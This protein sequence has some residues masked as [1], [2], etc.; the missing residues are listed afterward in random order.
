MLSNRWL[1]SLLQIAVLLISQVGLAGGG[2]PQLLPF[3]GRITDTGGNPINY[4]VTIKF[5]IYPPA[6]SCYIYEETQAVTPTS[7][8][9]ISVMLGAAANST[10]PANTFLNVYNNSP[11][12]TLVDSCAGLY[13]PGSN[14]W[15][16][17]ELVI[18]GTPMAGMQTIAA[19][20][21]AINA[22]MLDGLSSNQILQ[23]Q[24]P[25]LTQARLMGVVDG[26]DA[27]TLHHHD[28]VYL[29]TDGSNSVTGNISTTQNILATSASGRL[30][31]GL[32]SPLADIHIEKVSPTIRLG[33]IGGGGGSSAVDFYGGATRR[34]SI[35][36]QEGTNGLIIYSGATAA[37]N[38]SALGNVAF[39]NSVTVAG[40]TGLGKYTTAQEVPLISA[41]TILGAAA[42]GTVWVNSTTNTLRYWNG[43]AAITL[44]NTNSSVQTATAGTGLTNSGTATDP[45]FNVTYG[46]AA[47]TAI[48]GNSAFGGDVSGGYTSLSVNR[49]KSYPIDFTAVPTA[50]QYLTFVGG[51]W[52]A[53]TPGTLPVLGGGTGVTSLAGN[54]VLAM[55][56]IGTQVTSQVLSNGQILIGATGSAPVPASITAGS[57]IS[58]TPGPGSITIAANSPSPVGAS[59]APANVWVGSAGSVAAPVAITG[60]VTLSNAGVATLASSGVTAGAYSNVTVDAKG[61]V[62]GITALSPSNITTALGYTPLNKAGDVLTGSLGLNAVATD[63]TGLGVTDKG[64]VWFNTTAGQVKYWDG[65]AAQSLGIA[66]SGLTSLNSITGSTQ[67]FATGTSGVDFNIS[68]AASTHTFNLPNADATRRGALTSADWTTF[69]NKLSTGLATANIWVGNGSSVATPVAISGAATLASNGTLTLNTVPINRGG[70][71]STT[72]L[73]NNQIMVSSGGAIIEGGVMTNGQLLIG[74]TGLAPVVG[75][76]AGTANRITVT[77]GAGSITLSGPQDIHTGASPTFVGQTLSAGT[78]TSNVANSGTAVAFTMNSSANYTTAGAKLLSIANNSVEKLAVTK[79]GDLMINGSTVLSSTGAWSGGIVPASKG[80]TGFDGSTAANGRI[81]IGNGAGYTLANITQ[82]TNQG[83][84]ITNGAGSIMLDTAQDIRATASPTFMGQTLSA[85]TLTST[86]AN[87]VAAKA[88]TLNTSAAYTTSANLLSVQNNGVDR[89]SVVQDGSLLTTS[90]QTTSSVADGGTAK[91]FTLNTSTNYTNAGAKLLSIA[92]NSVEKLAVTKDGDLM[93]NG[94]TVLSSTGA[95]S[96]GIVPASK[97]GTGVDGSTATNGFLPIGNGAGYTLAGITGTTNR[98]SVSNGAGSITLSGPQD[99]HSGASPTFVGQTLS[100][101]TMTST[102]ADSASAKAFTLNSSTNYTT[103]GAKLLSVA[104]NGVERMAVTKDGDVTSRSLASSGGAIVAA[105]NNIAGPTAAVN[106]STGNVQ[107][108]QN[109]SGAALS[110]SGLTSGGAYSLI[111]ADTTSRTYTFGGSCTATSFVPANAPTK[112]GTRSIY[113]IIYTTN[114]GGGTCFISWVSGL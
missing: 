69:S 106:F 97:G 70:T 93:I 88:F 2:V 44:S 10:G 110:I 24:G 9:M 39:P 14:D 16:R 61:R 42:T 72:A 56:A 22:Q 104:N 4:P 92:N 6:G 84:T 47:N 38:I 86:V 27:S 64:K 52:V 75:S 78:M 101:G 5:R 85:G 102:V 98:I 114:V 62:T 89:F 81:P 3:Q 111:I 53:Q 25:N 19:A 33:A 76:I 23:V 94:S 107:V 59:L 18:D 58:I 113:T 82:N 83:V 65:A 66:G 108:L 51:N 32:P 99:I 41:L 73:T 79:D 46:S 112:S 74:S 63:P 71:N 87:G 29:R 55:N 17:L 90:G 13:A 50:G 109:A 40:T 34:A 26:T 105:D 8:G 54:G 30:G 68:S 67:T 49:L 57:G 100:A 60:D 36:A 48:Q 12:L 11:T 7:F 20:P 1:K 37:I 96:G 103:T 95:W 21:F 77:P 15:R 80:G 45:V 91:A 35:V 43:S 28:S 31:I